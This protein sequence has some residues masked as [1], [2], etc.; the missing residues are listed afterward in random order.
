MVSRVVCMSVSGLVTES[1]S[2]LEAMCNRIRNFQQKNIRQTGYFKKT[3][4]GAW[5]SGLAGV[6]VDLVGGARCRLDSGCR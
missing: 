4:G 5:L 1:L 2:D 6:E 3:V